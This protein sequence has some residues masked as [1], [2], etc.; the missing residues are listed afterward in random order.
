MNFMWNLWVPLNSVF[1][2]HRKLHYVKF[3]S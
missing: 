2:F 1:Q 3:M